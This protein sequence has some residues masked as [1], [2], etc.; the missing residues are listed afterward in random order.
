MLILGVKALDAPSPQHQLERAL[1]RVYSLYQDLERESSSK[2]QELELELN[3]AKSSARVYGGL[4]LICLLCPAKVL[5]PCFFGASDP[6]D[7]A[8]D[9]IT[10]L[11]QSLKAYQG[12]DKLIQ[13]LTDENL[14]LEEV[15][16]S[17]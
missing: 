6:R 7:H 13:E 2:I 10:E 3:H 4:S 12:S 16:I 9:T 8:Q 11:H 15:R 14:A 1:L 5:I 17:S